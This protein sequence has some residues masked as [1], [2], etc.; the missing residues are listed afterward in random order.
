MNLIPEKSTTGRKHLLILSL[1]ILAVAGAG[2]LS[3]CYLHESNNTLCEQPTEDTSLP[4]ETTQTME[5]NFSAAASVQTEVSDVISEFSRQPASAVAVTEIITE[6]TI[7]I[8]ES[9]HTYEETSMPAV[10]AE[11]VPAETEKL[12]NPDETAPEAVS[13]LPV[14]DTTAPSVTETVS[15]PVSETISSPILHA[16]RLA[17][18]SILNTHSFQ[19]ENFDVPN[20]ADISENEFAVYDVDHDGIEELIIR[21]SN[22][23]SSSAMGVIY[24]SDEE[25]NL[26]QELLTTSY[27]RFY[28][29]GII[30]AD[31]AHSSALSGDFWAYTL[32]QYN[33]SEKSYQQAGYVDARAKSAFSEDDT[34][35]E[36]FPDYADVS[37]TG[38]VYYI[39]PSD[40]NAVSGFSDPLDITDYQA[41]HTSFIG[42]ASE[43]SLPFQKFTESN[44]TNLE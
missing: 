6:E 4:D 32:Y 5:T 26:Y 8:T 41:W 33:S 15:E 7:L 3:V 34:A 22:T 21:W 38:M 44:I 18:E 35:Q 25:G 16:Y 29:N 17:L 11:T 19:G 28:S 24:G 13:T 31:S 27:M 14:Q 1:C 42:N 30:E 36:T 2:V 37:H 20:Q 39:Y 10:P 12:L 40:E 9:S 43:L 23:S